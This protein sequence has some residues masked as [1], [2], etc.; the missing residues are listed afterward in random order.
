[1]PGV[2]N[3]RTARK[4]R[5]RGRKRRDGDAAAA[6]SGRTLAERREDM[7]RTGKAKRDLDA[8]ERE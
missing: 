7:L 6:K 4:D 8:H 3:L 2:V 5:E 1:M